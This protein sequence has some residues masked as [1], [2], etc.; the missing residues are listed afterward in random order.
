MEKTPEIQDILDQLS[1]STNTIDFHKPNKITNQIRAYRDF[2]NF[3][4]AD[5]DL[6]FG[7]LAINN[8][9]VH[10]QIFKPK[11]HRATVFLLHGYLSHI[12]HLSHVIHDLNRQHFTVVSYDLQGHGLS[13]GKAASINTFYDYVATME[14]LLEIIKKEMPGRLYLIGHSTGASIIIDYCLRHPAAYFDKIILVAPLI[15]SNHW[16]LSNFAFYLTKLVP[17]IKTIKRK[18]RENSSDKRFLHDLK[19]D[20]LQTTEIPLNW[21]KAL[22]AWNKKINNYGSTKLPTFLIQ[23]NQDKTVDWKYNL[24]L[25]QDKFE[26]LQSVQID[27]GRH[28]LFN[29]SEPIRKI[30]FKEIQEFLND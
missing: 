8:K 17:F 25:I 21:V 28:E 24:D 20:P 2:Y 15:R 10:V 6:H 13:S 3:N 1:R 29:E 30:V 7:K 27:N 22:I 12:G 14:Q 23:G 11:H 26:N 5:I 9:T 18:F 19:Y 4:Q 16:Y